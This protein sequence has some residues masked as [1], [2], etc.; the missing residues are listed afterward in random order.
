[1]YVIFT[2]L[3]PLCHIVFILQLCIIV[4]NVEA[5]AAPLIAKPRD[6]PAEATLCSQQT[7]TLSVEFTQRA[8]RYD[9]NAQG[10]REWSY[11]ADYPSPRLTEMQ[12]Y[13]GLKSGQ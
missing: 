6:W 2:G 11:P 8:L 13:V 10:W 3:T 9:V 4:S 12:L 7:H 1:M 5:G